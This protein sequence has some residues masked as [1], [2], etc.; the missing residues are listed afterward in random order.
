MSLINCQ[1]VY[2]KTN[3]MVYYVKD[4]DVDIVGLAETWLSNNEQNS[5]K[6]IGDITPN[7]IALDT[8][9]DHDRG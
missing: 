7:V 2:S 9:H 1:S 6:L 3:K 4:R 5:N 8:W